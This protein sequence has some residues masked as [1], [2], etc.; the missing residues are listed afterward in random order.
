MADAISISHSISTASDQELS[1][2]ATAVART[3]SD[4]LSPAVM[5]IP[6]LLLGVWASDVP[7]TYRFALLY[8][9]VAV[10]L[11]VLYVLWMVKSGRVTD[12][13]LPER[14]DRIGPFVLSILSG[15]AA[16]AL[17]IYFGAPT[18]FV[19]PVV[20]AQTQTLALLLVTLAWQISI[21]TATTAG[22]VTFAILALGSEASILALLVPLVA[23]ARIYLKRHTV[24]QTVA[25]ACLGCLAFTT[26]FALRGI[27]W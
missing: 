24:A 22:L 16:T 7:G 9:F 3:V 10:P 20:T 13:H 15:V 21:H 8:F 6:C 2:P 5:A 11:P 14:R 25:G 4:I 19:A 23:W 1:R 12:F 17:L 18:I 26:L 27:V